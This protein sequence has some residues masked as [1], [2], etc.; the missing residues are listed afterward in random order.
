MRESALATY[1]PLTPF[2]QVGKARSRA[3]HA[4]R[5]L[6]GTEDECQVVIVPKKVKA[7]KIKGNT[8]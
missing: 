3:T 1:G 7:R 4:P 8:V 5:Q 2:V 6:S